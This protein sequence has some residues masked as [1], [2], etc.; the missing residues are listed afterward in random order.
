M[1]FREDRPEVFCRDCYWHIYDPQTQTHVCSHR[2]GSRL[3]K[4]ALGLELHWIPLEERNGH[5]DCP[6][7]RPH[8]FWPTLWR[9]HGLKL[10]GIFV[11]W[12]VLGLYLAWASRGLR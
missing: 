11:M 3:V 10:L 8:R 4:T 5:N 9:N 7:F 2:H 12:A 1:A 6:D